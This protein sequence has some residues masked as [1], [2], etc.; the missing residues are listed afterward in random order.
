[1]ASFFL[2]VH[3]LTQVLTDETDTD[4]D[5]DTNDLAYA[6]RM[7]PFMKVKQERLTRS[8]KVHGVTT[9]FDPARRGAQFGGTRAG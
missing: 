3:E 1:M 6:Q 8:M 4:S 7:K 5:Q 2:V 9:T